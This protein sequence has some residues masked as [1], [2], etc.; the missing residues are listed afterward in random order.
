MTGVSYGLA[1]YIAATASFL[2]V[3]LIVAARAGDAARARQRIPFGPTQ[4]FA[5]TVAQNGDGANPMI[6]AQER[7]AGYGPVLARPAVRRFLRRLRAGDDA[8][9]ADDDA[10]GRLREENFGVPESQYGFIMATN[11]AMVVL[12][13]YLVTR[14]SQRHSP[15]RSLTLGAAFYAAGAGSVALFHS[16]WGFWRA[17]WC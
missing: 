7:A 5:P 2:F 17:W 10:A 15:W 11:A 16:F 8:R 9:F 1:F 14:W 12:F 3:A 4:G 13:Q 6:S